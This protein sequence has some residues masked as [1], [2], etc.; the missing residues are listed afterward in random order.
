MQ[1]IC[2]TA[3]EISNLSPSEVIFSTSKKPVGMFFL[4]RGIF[5][6]TCPAYMVMLGPSPSDFVGYIAEMAILTRGWR[7]RGLLR[8]TH[9]S[10]VAIVSS[11][12][13]QSC[14]GDFP[15]WHNR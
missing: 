4:L 1:T 14:L 11:K 8:A 12:N 15:M 2:C 13:L 7:H 5:Q 6:Y 3:C 9:Y 10:N